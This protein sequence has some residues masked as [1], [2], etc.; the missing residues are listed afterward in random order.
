MI[1]RNMLLV[2]A[3]SIL[4][5]STSSKLQAVSSKQT[6]MSSIAD[7]YD[8]HEVVLHVR[9]VKAELLAKDRICYR[10]EI[11]THYKGNYKGYL[12][13]TAFQKAAVG[14][15]Y[16]IA[17]DV[18]VEESSK[19]VGGINLRSADGEIFYP[20]I[21]SR[22]DPNAESWIA[23]KGVALTK[24]FGSPLRDGS[25][26]CHADLGSPDIDNVC[27]VFGSIVHW[28]AVSQE[29]THLKKSRAAKNPAVP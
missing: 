12:S 15:D 10:A 17:G 26:L 22:L 29:L 25:E 3:F 1:T 23:L 2:C 18:A 9:L 11:L 8:L 7:L 28:D 24:S 5:L 16:L 14:A 6:A 4:C 13:F 21:S 27:D 20:I 19:C